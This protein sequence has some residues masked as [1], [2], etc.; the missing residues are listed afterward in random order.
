MADLT[1]E[2]AMNIGAE[3]VRDDMITNTFECED[4]YLMKKKCVICGDILIGF[5]NNAEPVCEGQ[6]CDCCNSRVVIQERLR[7]SRTRTRSVSHKD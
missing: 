5:G 2:I 7:Q 6:C 4:E 1:E 3:M